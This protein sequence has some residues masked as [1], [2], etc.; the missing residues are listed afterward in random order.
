MWIRPWLDPDYPIEL[1]ATQFTIM[2]GGLII[3]MTPLVPNVA[4]GAHLGGLAAGMLIAAIGFV[5]RR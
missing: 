4:N 2:M 5:M 3:C 1:D